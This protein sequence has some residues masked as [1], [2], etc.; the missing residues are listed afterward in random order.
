MINEICRQRR[1]E[2]K[3]TYREIAEKTGLPQDSVI[4]YMT[5]EISK[6]PSVYTVG[7]ICAALGVSLDEYFGI[8]T[9][10]A[11]AEERIAEL[12]TRLEFARKT[13]MTQL[14]IIALLA[15]CCVIFLFYAMTMDAF[16]PLAGLIRG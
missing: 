5:R 8:D 7:K 6:A 2:L 14:R 11:S 13:H 1:E 15:V 12:E 10:N 9:G 3:M 16:A 4:K